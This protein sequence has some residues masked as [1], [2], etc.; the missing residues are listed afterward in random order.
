MTMFSLHNLR[1]HGLLRPGRYSPLD[2]A[3]NDSL[4]NSLG[5]SN[6]DIG[7]GEADAASV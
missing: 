1:M 6:F 3:L 2:D 5:V 7:K 4:D